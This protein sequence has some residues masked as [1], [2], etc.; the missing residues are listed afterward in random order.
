M[1]YARCVKNTSSIGRRPQLL[2]SEVT[3]VCNVYER[4]GVRIFCADVSTLYSE[5]D[6]PIA[7][8]SD[9]PYGVG[10]FPGDPPTY[11]LLA[12]WYEPHIAMWTAKATPQTTLWFWNTEIG[13]AT[14][15]PVLAKYGWRYVRCNVWD[16][17]I[18][19]VAGNSNTR[20]LRELP[21]VTEVCVQY[22][23]EPYINGL[24]LKDWLRY[25]W[26]RTGLP[27]S[28]ANEACGVANAATRKYL[29]SDHL[30]YFP[31][32]EMFEKM[33]AYAN[34]YGRPE[35]RPYFSLDG[36]LPMTADQW[37]QMRAKFHCK[38]GITNVWREPPLHNGERVKINGK[39]AHLNQKPLK[40]I[41]LIIELS[42]DEGDLI[43]EPFGGLCTAAVAAFRLK[44]RCFSAEIQRHLFEMAVERLIY[45]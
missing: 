34:T 12:E 14:V 29:T 11:D 38:L 21:V 42:T 27:L 22:V 15:H 39:A 43:W 3:E 10:G 44:R 45:A 25:E 30:W 8:I 36:K 33:A 9:G 17:G 18:S 16:K 41:E 32:P 37:S 23:K 35:G 13:W 20:V 24:S 2:L 28:K 1:A 7:I 19:H 26:K 5:W 40:L 6:P 31:P 4:E